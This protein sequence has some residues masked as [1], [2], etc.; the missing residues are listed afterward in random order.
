MCVSVAIM[1]Y[2]LVCVVGHLRYGDLMFRYVRNYFFE[3]CS[4]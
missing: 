2:L 1:D 3:S 4:C